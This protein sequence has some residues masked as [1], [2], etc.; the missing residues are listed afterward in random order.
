MVIVTPNYGS[1]PLAVTT[2]SRTSGNELEADDGTVS[3]SLLTSFTVH[4]YNTHIDRA[5]RRAR[6]TCT[7]VYAED[8]IHGQTSKEEGRPS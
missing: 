3:N 6:V 1:L 2:R 5:Y 8:E 7:G 4:V